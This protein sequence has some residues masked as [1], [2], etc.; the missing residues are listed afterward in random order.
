MVVWCNW[1]CV[2]E[3]SDVSPDDDVQRRCC[4]KWF[5]RASYDTL[6]SRLHQWWIYPAALVGA[7]CCL[8]VAVLS[9][10]G[11]GVLVLLME[12]VG[13][14]TTKWEVWRE[15]AKIWR[16]R[17]AGIQSRLTWSLKKARKMTNDGHSVV[18][19]STTNSTYSPTWPWRPRWIDYRSI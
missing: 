10:V 7:V 14:R 17:F 13:A 12:R 11:V 6:E 4:S 3:P 18:R 9:S 19:P 2:V 16:E 15:E 5:C 1:F 8:T